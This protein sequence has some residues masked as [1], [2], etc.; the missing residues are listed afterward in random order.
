MKRP[1]RARTFTSHGPSRQD[2]YE[3]DDAWLHGVPIEH[4]L[5]QQPG[6]VARAANDDLRHERQPA[7]ELLPQSR[8]ADALPDHK[9]TRRADVDGVEVRE[10]F[11]EDAWPERPMTADVHAPQEHHECHV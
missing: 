1:S 4:A 2:A 8:L 10:L 7:L 9:R 11:R 5:G 6:D 3:A